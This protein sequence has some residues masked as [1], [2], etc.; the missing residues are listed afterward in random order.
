MEKPLYDGY[1]WYSDQK[2]PKVLKQEA[3][4]LD[5]LCESE[6]PFIIEGQLWNKDKRESI[7]IKYVDGKYIV[8]G[9]VVVEDY[10]EEKTELFTK[11]R[12]IPHRIEGIKHI[13]FLQ[14]WRK[15]K[16]NLCEG[17]ETLVPDRLVFVG[18]EY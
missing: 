17:F 4:N 2:K 5:A 1:L 7:S 6:N 3:F 15:E 11:K 12:Y 9:P 14:Y 16:D 8:S 13:V 10:K 18:F